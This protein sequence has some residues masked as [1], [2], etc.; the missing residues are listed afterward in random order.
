MYHNDRRLKE[1]DTE[2]P[3]LTFLE[4]IFEKN[5]V[6]FIGYGLEELEILEYV[7]QKGRKSTSGEQ[8]ESKHFILQGFFSHEVQLA[9]FL[10]NYYATECNVQL[11]PFL[12]DENDWGQLLNV[13]E[14]FADKIPISE[15]LM[16]QERLVM[17]KLIEN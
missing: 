14:E 11:I 15:P 7:I 6:L 17:E 12:R 13:L 16:A 10:E 1:G 4:N 9:E 3:I 8:K 5:S 2:N